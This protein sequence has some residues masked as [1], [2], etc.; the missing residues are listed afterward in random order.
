MAPELTADTQA[1]K[2][3][4]YNDFI[5]CCDL[6]P[7][8]VSAPGCASPYP[9]TFINFDDLEC[10]HNT[11]TSKDTG[12]FALSDVDLTT[13]WD[14]VL[15]DV[16]FEPCDGKHLYCLAVV[17]QT[18][19]PVRPATVQ[20]VADITRLLGEADCK[21]SSDVDSVPHENG[22][23][24][25]ST[26]TYH[27]K[28]GGPCDHCGATAS[29]QWRRGP[30]AKPVLCNACGTRYRRTNQ[31]GPSPSSKLSRV[32][33]R[34]RLHQEEAHKVGCAKQQRLCGGLVTCGA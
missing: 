25:Q 18:G 6:G 5:G 23:P 21:A 11:S 12:F 16:S 14:D 15:S 1:V 32:G 27:Y 10:S 34:K 31:L 13:E 2:P 8:V 28:T 22:K 4:N 24:Q 20:E 7:C 30:P 3:V 29:P 33:S 19:L 9:T 17:D 26:S